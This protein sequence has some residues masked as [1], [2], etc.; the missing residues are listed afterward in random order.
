MTAAERIGHRGYVASRAVS[1]QLT[2]QRV[3]NLVIRD[4]ATRKSLIYK[5]SA[6]EYAM[7]SC[8]MVLEDV[9]GELPA[10]QGVIAFSL[11]MLP[12]REER[13]RAIYDRVLAAGAEFHAALEN[14][15]IAS[16]ADI[17]TV[18]DIF[19]V[20]K[21]ALSM[22]PSDLSLSLYSRSQ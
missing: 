8:Y 13:R 12:E 19:L 20:R 15:V 4:Y 17:E 10:L 7:P 18:E 22:D 5:L 21:N 16:E 1:G 3:Q 14:L 2:P 6:V 11:F 9:I